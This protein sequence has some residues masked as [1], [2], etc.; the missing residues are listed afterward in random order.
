MTSLTEAVMLALLGL[1]VGVVASPVGIGGGFI[2]AP[3]LL[4][5]Y[6][7][8]PGSAAGTSLLVVLI[9][10]VSATLAYLRQRRVDVKM[11]LG[12][13][14]GTIPGSIAGSLTTTVV[15]SGT[16]R[17]YFALMLILSALYLAF[18]SRMGLSSGGL[19]RSGNQRLMKDRLGRE[20]VYSFNLH[21]IIAFGVISGFISGFFGVGG[22]IVHV[23]VMIILLG[24]P[25]YIATATSHFILVPAA[26]TG[27]STH[28]VLG[29]I[30][31]VK[32]GLIAA[33]VLLGAQ[34][35]AKVSEKASSRTLEMLFALFLLVVAINMLLQ[36]SV[37]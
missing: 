37:G 20:H 11:G 24:V 36:A 31:I 21:L 3:V 32:G 18:R 30:D 5:L 34:I 17:V 33:G 15:S 13:S 16:F 12:F 35:G 1:A 10:A 7:F 6:N 14:S 26:L 22:G 19:L 4:M 27:I 28:A 9:N 29:H 8:T 2:V 25:A 23:P